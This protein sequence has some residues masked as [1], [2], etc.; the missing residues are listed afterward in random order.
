MTKTFKTAALP[1]M[2]YIIFDDDNEIY[3]GELLEITDIDTANDRCVLIV[4]GVMPYRAKLKV[5]YS[6]LDRNLL[7][8][9]TGV[10]LFLD[11]P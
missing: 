4:D 8:F 5:P 9:G 7:D 1:V 2:I 10:K 6:S 11:R 3:D